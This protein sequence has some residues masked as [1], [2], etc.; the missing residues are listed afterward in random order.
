MQ[1]NFTLSEMESTATLDKS[2]ISSKMQPQKET[3][4]KILQFAAVYKT[5]KITD[6]W[7]VNI[8]FN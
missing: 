3:L 7:I 1:E 2:Y 6:K 8:C 4:Q 5:E